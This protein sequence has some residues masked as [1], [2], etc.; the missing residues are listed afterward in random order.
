MHLASHPSRS[1]LANF[2]DEPEF[3]VTAMLETPASDVQNGTASV[4]LFVIPITSEGLRWLR[5]SWPAK[6]RH[7]GSGWPT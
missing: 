5:V 6:D 1:F 7:R 2:T 3:L 4:E